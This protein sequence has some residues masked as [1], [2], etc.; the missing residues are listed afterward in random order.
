M[1]AFAL[2]VYVW[3]KN[4]KLFIPAILTIVI[5][6]VFCIFFVP[7][8][9]NRILYLLSPEYFASSMKGGRI[10]RAIDGFNLFVNNFWTG[11]GLGQY[12]GSVALSHKLNKSVS[13][14]NYYLKTAVEMG[15]FG[16]IALLALL[17][18][19]VA[20]CSRALSKIR[21]KAQKEWARGIVAGI[22]GIVMYNLLENMLE[23]PLISSYFWMLAGVVM[24]LG[25]GQYRKE[26]EPM[27]E[28][29]GQIPEPRET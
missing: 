25:Y 21:D 3:L 22:F 9:A 23:I 20:W 14:D 17:Y 26:R 13:L 6:F 4:K 1:C 8:V 19:T 28:D 11:M 15:I 29:A 27:P 18:G 7:P 10:I 24:F 12:G 16:L 5:L 2:A